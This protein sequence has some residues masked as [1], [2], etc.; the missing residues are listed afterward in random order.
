MVIDKRPAV[1]KY[2]LVYDKRDYDHLGSFF[3]IK[4]VF[5]QNNS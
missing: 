4:K 1:I 3:L 2:H 5:I